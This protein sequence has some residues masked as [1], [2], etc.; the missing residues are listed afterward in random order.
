VLPQSR[1]HAFIASLLGIPHIVVCINKMDLVEFREDVFE[2]IRKDFSTFATA[3]SIRDLHF[4]P[5]SALLGDNVVERS[6]HMPWFEGGSLLHYL[7]TVHIASDRNYKDL[8]FPVQYVVRPN[9]DFRGFAGQL[10]SGTVR[11]GDPIM[12][13]PSGRTSKVASVV[14]YD[15]NLDQAVP[16][17]SVT[18][19]LEDEVDVS[20][21]D[22]LV[23]P[24]ACPNVSRR[25]EAMVVWMNQ[26]PLQE[27]KPYL[28]KHT[29]STVKAQVKKIQYRVDI[30][31]LGHVDAAEL[32]MNEIGH[33]S[34]EALRPIFFDPYE[35]NR[36]TGAFILIDPLTN[37]TVGAGMIRGLQARDAQRP[38]RVLD[39]LELDIGRVTLA[40]RIARAGHLPFTLW[41]TGDP[42]VAYSLERRLFDR[43]SQ[44]HVI[45]GESSPDLLPEAARI[46]NAAGVIAICSLPAAD[47]LA[48]EDAKRVVGE[49]R[50]IAIE[51]PA[52]SPPEAANEI[53]RTLETKGFL[54]A[55]QFFDS[56]EG[57]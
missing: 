28:L 39:G 19:T 38:T 44:V 57:I 8:R 10:A 46:L 53:C 11:P 56:G 40:E 5:I 21:G 23:N 16:P 18:I 36:A 9:L 6:K 15:G 2:R 7:E 34:V 27:N 24:T 55:T 51:N 20:R 13:L 32:Q 47:P 22:M 37:E 14:T 25:L 12:V 33:V 26:T 42:E 45:A 54:R 29:T 48:I 3:L 49:D 52:G 41:L 30:N 1:R 43:G 4:I 31:T 50:F 17:M 35:H